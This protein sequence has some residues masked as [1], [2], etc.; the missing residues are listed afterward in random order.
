MKAMRLFETVDAE[1]A[2]IKLY[3]SLIETMFHSVSQCV[4]D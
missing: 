2:S 1:Q 4:T 3:A